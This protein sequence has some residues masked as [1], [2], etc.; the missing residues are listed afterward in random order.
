ML[1]N[2]LK[3]AYR[4][5]V[6]NKVY[7]LINVLGLALSMFCAM[8]IILW[9]NDE[10]SY[11]SFWPNSERIYRLVQA[12]EFNDGTVFRVASNPA[13]MPE[14]LKE[15]NP[16]IAEYTRFRP[17]T[18]QA[19]IRYNEA[20]FYEDVTFVDSTFLKVFQLP[21]LVGNPT[22]ALF[23][24]NSVVITAQTAKKYFGHDWQ[25]QE[26]LGKTITMNQHHSFAVSGVIKDLPSNTHFDF[27][28]ILPFRKLYEYGWSMSWGNN[29]YYAY[30]LLGK[31]VDAE[32]LSAQI[33]RFAETRDDIEDN[34]YLQALSDMHLYSDFDIDVYGSTEPRYPYVRIF[35]VVALAIIL[36]ACINFMNLS[37]AQSERRA[38]EIGLRK[39]VGSRR[40]QIVGQLLSESVLLSLLALLIA[41]VAVVLVLPAFNH[42]VDKS[43]RLDSETWSIG[44]AFIGGAVLVGL[45]AGSY[46]SLFLSGFK[47]VQVLKGGFTA[48]RGGTVFRRVLVVTQFAV[49]II[50]ILGT[51]VVYRQFQ[52]VMEKDL[53]YDK[54]LLVYM[55]I[56]G[57]IMA[58]YEGFKNDLLQQPLVK[59][60]T[61][62]SDIPTHSTRA[63]FVNWDGQSD[64]DKILFHH[65]TVD[66]D[67]VETMGLEV[68][69]G[70]DFSRASADT[71][72]YIINE[73]AAKLTGFA[74]PVGE[75]ITMDSHE[76]TIIGIVKNFNFKSLHQKLEPLV[77]HMYY[78]P[79]YILVKT[80]PGNTATSLSSIETSWSKHNPN[81]PFEYHFLD[82]EYERLYQSE[83]RMSDIFDYFTFFT[84]FI[85]CLGLIG[86]IN[87]M[88]EKRTKEVSIRKIL[89]ASVSSILVLLSHEY[90]RLILIAFVIAVPVAHYFISDW[91]SNFA[92]QVD[93]P[94]WLYVVPGLLVL[95][96]ALLSVSA[97]TLRAARRN[98]VD[99]LRYE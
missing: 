64:D 29:Y 19:L 44:I 15:Q 76:G 83:K 77:L 90:V 33:A 8:L 35:I 34:F 71:A 36:I 68:L 38:K 47:P 58:N 52:Y 84:L 51:T 25:Q 97:Q 14:L 80:A 49:T 12:P 1:R 18:D 67:Y 50:L 73:E 87:H 42:I 93:V 61:V 26:V 96:I 95:L 89:G 69:E 53:G 92:Y 62:A 72:N 4:N 32:D 40:G 30:F 81:Y 28:I 65:F 57:D 10:L 21:F 22:N 5:F 86:L 99:S 98:P 31:D 3:I 79:S 20:Q 16:G 66:F 17:N 11:E 82:E 46:P 75:K 23:D 74:S 54:D 88:I 2:Y 60:V 9:I 56:R 55:P 43:I 48:Q 37:T 6:R 41:G 70:R 85:A 91:L 94:W 78:S 7:S 63:N 13:P 59:K 24:P 27:D 39:T 45:L